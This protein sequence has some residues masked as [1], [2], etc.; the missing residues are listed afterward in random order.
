ME[1]DRLDI[2]TKIC[3]PWRRC[4]DP[5]AVK[6]SIW[7]RDL[8]ERTMMLKCLNQSKARLTKT[9]WVPK[10]VGDKPSRDRQTASLSQV[11]LRVE[12]QVS[13]QTLIS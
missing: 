6:A 5:W 2:E 3:L 4:Q 8:K 1:K 13:M 11:S 7:V 10:K 9:S 12:N